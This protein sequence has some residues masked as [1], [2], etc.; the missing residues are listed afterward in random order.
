MPLSLKTM[1]VQVK[2]DHSNKRFRTVQVSTAIE[3][4]CSGDCGHSRNILV[5]VCR[6]GA[7]SQTLT[8]LKTK[9]VLQLTLFERDLILLP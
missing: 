3:T 6:R 4:L 2:G 5:E 8:L 9:N 1:E 7:P